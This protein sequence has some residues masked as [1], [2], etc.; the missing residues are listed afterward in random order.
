[1][2]DNSDFIPRYYPTNPMRTYM[3]SVINGAGNIVDPSAQNVIVNGDRNYVG[4]R[5]S[6]I[7]ILNSSGCVINPDVVGAVII[8]SSGV[9]I[10]DDNLV[11]IN[12][13]LIT[14]ASLS[15]GS[16][17]VTS[18]GAYTMTVANETLDIQYSGSLGDY[19]LPY[20]VGHNKK[21]IIKN[22]TLND[23]NVL[24]QGSDTIDGNATITIGTFDSIT[25]QSNGISNYIII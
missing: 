7:T 2:S 15:T 16:Y 12:N 25:V 9:T 5:A 21:F 1:M 13:T 17:V 14:N 11:Y 24:R 18:L 23:Q 4:G 8:N 3:D 10:S 20:A 19:S 22:N 6:N